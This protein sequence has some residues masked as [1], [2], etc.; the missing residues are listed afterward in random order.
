[1][2]NPRRPSRNTYTGGSTELHRNSE[3]F[4]GKRGKWE[5]MKEAEVD[6]VSP[7]FDELSERIIGAAIEV[8]KQLGPGF[9]ETI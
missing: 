1:M 9:L 7:K 4:H 3:F 2:P 6:I 5:N 8:H